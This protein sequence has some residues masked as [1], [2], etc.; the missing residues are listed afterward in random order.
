[1]DQ[2]KKRHNPE[3]TQEDLKNFGI[4]NEDQA[5]KAFDRN[6]DS[7]N[8]SLE[9]KLQ[10]EKGSLALHEEF[11]HLITKIFGEDL[12]LWTN[13]VLGY[14]PFEKSNKSATSNYS[15]LIGKQTKKAGWFKKAEFENYIRA[16]LFQIPDRKD[17]ETGVVITEKSLPMYEN[18]K[19]NQIKIR[20]YKSDA[21]KQ[22]REFVKAY[23]SFT[24]QE[25]T[26]IQECADE[27]EMKKHLP[28]KETIDDKVEDPYRLVGKTF[29]TEEIFNGKI[30][31]SVAIKSRLA[32][33]KVDLMGTKANSVAL[34]INSVIMVYNLSKQNYG[35]ALFTLGCALV[36]GYFVHVRSKDTLSRYED[37]LKELYKEEK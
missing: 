36:N 35:F 32:M 10:S 29:K 30:K 12:Y 28:E 21:L 27:E 37:S 31:P 22:A 20:V 34:G 17:P 1:M 24:G 4:N 5:V 23:K 6:N 14:Q 11:C 16:E 18:G 3:I 9:G 25:V 2:V 19:F 15:W 13:S 8:D 26:L 33:M 7:A